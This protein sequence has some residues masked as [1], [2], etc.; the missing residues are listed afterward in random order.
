MKSF[1]SPNFTAPENPAIGWLACVF[2]LRQRAQKLCDETLFPFSV[3]RL[4]VN[5]ALRARKES[6]FFLFFLFFFWKVS[7]EIGAR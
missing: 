6:F 4:R 3:L 5:S 7:V 2:S 1:K